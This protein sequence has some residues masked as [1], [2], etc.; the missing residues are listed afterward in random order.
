MGDFNID[1]LTSDTNGL[2][3]LNPMEYYQ[4]TQLIQEAARFKDKS[5][6]LLHHTFT[7]T[8]GKVRS[9]KVPRIYIVSIF[10]LLCPT[11]IHLVTNYSRGR[12]N[13][14]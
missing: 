13:K 5:T 14:D 1:L 4:F 2:S 8:P 11:S 9:T 7:S 6:T 12:D 10:V 3:W